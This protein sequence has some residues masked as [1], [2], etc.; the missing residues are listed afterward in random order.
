MMRVHCAAL[1]GLFL[2]AFSTTADAACI[3]I[4]NAT[5]L[6]NIRDNMAGDCC[7]TAN[8]NAASLGNFV[9]LG[10]DPDER[11]FTGTLDG[12]GFAIS[13]LKIDDTTQT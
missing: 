2:T 6:N 13:N 4:G 12:K 3:L 11:F 7:L 1:F 10:T 9:P 5:Q 8:I